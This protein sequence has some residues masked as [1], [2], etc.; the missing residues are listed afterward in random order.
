MLSIKKKVHNLKPLLILVGGGGRLRDI[1]VHH[2]F[3]NPHPGN[4][5]PLWSSN[6]LEAWLDLLM[7][8]K[9][10]D[11]RSP[12]TH[13]QL[14]A[15]ASACPTFTGVWRSWWRLQVRPPG[16]LTSHMLQLLFPST[17]QLLSNC[18]STSRPA[19][20]FARCHRNAFRTC[21]VS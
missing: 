14:K 10:F 13:P 5:P 9:G 18:Y 11:S 12:S 8:N 15:R 1:H 20:K 4:H 6:S 7:R 17:K 21:H 19:M 3:L 2:F 16:E